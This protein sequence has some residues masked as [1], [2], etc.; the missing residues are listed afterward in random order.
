MVFFGTNYEA[1][2]NEEFGVNS[3]FN[4]EILKILIHRQEELGNI[5]YSEHK[6]RF[7]EL[8]EK[9]LSRVDDVFAAYLSTDE[10]L[11]VDCRHLANGKPFS[12]PLKKANSALVLSLSLYHFL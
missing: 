7:G 12:Y 9:E 11:M 1:H 5:P 2:I 3:Y 8:F 6:Q 10:Y 4:Y